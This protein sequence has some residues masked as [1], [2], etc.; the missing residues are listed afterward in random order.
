MKR[1]IIIQI[2]LALASLYLPLLL[3]MPLTGGLYL[4]GYKGAEIK[5]EAFQVQAEIPMDKSELRSFFIQQFES[6]KIDFDFEE[7]KESGNDFLFR[8]ST[9][10]Y[11][12][13]SKTSDSAITFYKIEPNLLRKLIEIH[14]G[15]GP[16]L[17]KWFEISFAV[18]LIMTALSGL[19]LSITVPKYR[20]ITWI[21]FTLGA[22]V[23]L[24]CLV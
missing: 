3:L 7:I 2:H 12:S 24:I 11:Y 17:M 6:Q 1:P 16:K 18:A 9:R 10:T 4:L 23:I 5:S 22:A 14:K 13:A 15:H 20:R 21:S 8:P 19:W